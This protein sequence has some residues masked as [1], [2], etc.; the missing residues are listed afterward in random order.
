MSI[1]KNTQN[2]ESLVCLTDQTGGSEPVNLDLHAIYTSTTIVKLHADSPLRQKQSPL[3]S[4]FPHLG[5]YIDFLY[6][7]SHCLFFGPSILYSTLS[8]PIGYSSNHLSFILP[9]S[10]PWILISMLW[11]LTISKP[12][13]LFFRFVL[14]NFVCEFGSATGHNSLVRCQSGC[15]CEGIF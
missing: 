7:Y 1:K 2:T 3:L 9:S 4:F 12:F 11:R 5:H 15:L 6:F 14:I 8:L 10:V 13:L